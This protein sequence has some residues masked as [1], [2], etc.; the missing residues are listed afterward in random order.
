MNNFVSVFEE[1]SKLY[2]EEP[3]VS[4]KKINED[5]A[6]SGSLANYRVAL[7]DYEDDDGYDQENIE[8][9][10]KPGQ[11]KGDLVVDL[12]YNAGFVSIYVHDEREATADEIR[13]LAGTTFDTVPGMNY[14]DFGS[15]DVE[16]W[17]DESLHESDE[18]VDDVPA[19]TDVETDAEAE[20]PAK[21]L[22]LECSKCGALVIKAEED[23]TVDETTDLANTDEAC[24]ACEEAE[25]FKIVGELL[26]YA[27]V[28]EAGDEA[29]DDDIEESVEPETAS[30]KPDAE[31]APSEPESAPSKESDPEPAITEELLES[32]LTEGKFMN[33]VKKVLTRVGADA[34]TIGRS[35]AELGDEI[36]NIDNKGE[37]KSSK[38]YDF[39]EYVEN[40]AVL[41]ALINGNET[42]LNT[43]TKE[44]IEDLAKDI[45]DYKKAKTEDSAE[46]DE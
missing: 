11:T 24:T 5:V 23:V 21:Q 16:D 4:S 19:D 33:N 39:M 32:V 42:V 22:V 3:Q 35:F 13:A 36:L 46:D 9:L 27:A 14:E 43:C 15:V 10:L 40:K 6:T 31:P 29:G 20:V 41:K 34:A 45:E 30:Q 12:S 2:D 38:L 37:W 17:L 44:D 25:G 26:P 1:L 18:E 8:Y 7:A 28:D